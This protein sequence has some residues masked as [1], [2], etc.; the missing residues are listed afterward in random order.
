MIAGKF[1]VVTPT[2][3]TG[4]F[5]AETIESVLDNL[6]SGDEYFIIDGA[7]TDNSIDIIRSY[8]SQISG[9]VSEPDSGYQEGLAKGFRRCSGEFLCWI[10][11]SDLLLSGA[12]ESASKALVDT[13][14]DLIF[15]DDLFI[16]ED[17]C[18]ICR[19]YGGVNSLR[20]AMLYGGWTPLQ[21]A[22]FWRR[23]LYE[24]VG[25]MNVQMKYAA[26]YDFFL[27][28]ACSGSCQYVAKIFSAFRRHRQQKSIA[29][30]REYEA[31]RQESRR[32]VLRH[33][34]VG[35]ARRLPAELFYYLIIRWR[36]HVARRFWTQVV[37][38]GTRV[39]KVSVTQT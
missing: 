24:R 20:N 34:Q 23:S 38:A 39:G 17:S 35:F 19:S 5:L 7:S 1:S 8:E 33:L 26:D 28:A 2:F 12:L 10:N 9:W 11:S 18:V 14:A 15:G 16:D 29:G 37:P 3:N 36:H 4:H 25:G 6:C 30:V 27:R 21:D 22:C 31:E 13:K 32:R